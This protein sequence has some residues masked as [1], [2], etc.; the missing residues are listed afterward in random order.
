[1]FNLTG[2][3]FRAREKLDL[4]QAKN[5]MSQSRNTSAGMHSIYLQNFANL[6]DLV[7]RDKEPFRLTGMDPDL[8]RLHLIEKENIISFVRSKLED[9][10]KEK[11]RKEI[12]TSSK[13]NLYSSMKDGF[14]E[15][16]YISDVKYYI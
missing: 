1:M 4:R 11:F 3:T 16:Q 15:E 2:H 5:K 7:S 12:G 8:T 9:H 14:K 6:S 10:F 13:L